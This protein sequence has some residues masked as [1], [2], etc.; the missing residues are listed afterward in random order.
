MC[1]QAIFLHR[2]TGLGVVWGDVSRQAESSA[3]L[4]MSLR[5]DSID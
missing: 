4:Y 3:G 2:F 5:L 1:A